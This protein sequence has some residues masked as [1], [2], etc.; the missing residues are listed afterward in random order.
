MMKGQ[1]KLDRRGYIGRDPF[2]ARTTRSGHLRRFQLAKGTLAS[3]GALF[4][5]SR[6]STC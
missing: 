1:K 2:G 4:F 6:L 3:A 5:Q